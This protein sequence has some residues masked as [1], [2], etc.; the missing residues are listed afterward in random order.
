MERCAPKGVNKFNQLNNIRKD[1][2]DKQIKKQGLT[3]NFDKR[4]E[5]KRSSFQIFQ[6]FP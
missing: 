1:V 2:D 5:D 3:A 6:T 4:Y